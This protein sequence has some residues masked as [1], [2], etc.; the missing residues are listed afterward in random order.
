MLKSALWDWSCSGR[1]I[2]GETI[3]AADVVCRSINDA[4][5][6]SSTPS[7]TATLRS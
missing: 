6:Y 1:G 3:P 2:A 7:L 5:I 4:L